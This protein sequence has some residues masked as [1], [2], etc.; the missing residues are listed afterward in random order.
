MK[1]GD[2][3]LL[4]ALVPALLGLPGTGCAAPAAAPRWGVALDGY[5]IT[6]AR[7]DEVARETTLR[8]RLVAFFQQWP[9]DPAGRNF[10]AESLAAIAAAGAEPVITWE[11]MYY[12]RADG[13]EVMI[14]AEQITAGV[15]DGYLEDYARQ[16]AAW[17]RPV[18]LRFAHEMNL[19]RYHW[20]SDEAGYGPSSPDRYVRM[21]RHV[22]AVFRR[23]GAANVRWA[24]CPNAESVPG[25]GN[26]P[27]AGWNVARAYY[28]GDAWVDL[29]GMDGYNWG[30]TQVPER[31]G[32]RSHW[33]SAAET[34]GAI[35]RELTALAPGKPLLIMETACAPTGGSKAAW[36]AEL[37]A[38]A[39]DW[40]LDGVIW[41]QANKEVDWRLHPGLSA[42]ELAA[43]RA[44]FERTR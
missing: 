35:R 25:P 34:F 43:F 12:R 3:A 19:R 18:I 40:K 24:F 32:W 2:L 10:P 31:H 42:A 27:D 28:P 6:A 8:P 14:S 26:A 30:D 9:E 21:W 29:L 15:Y 7:L 13:R 38:V 20:G 44:A 11:P 1:R 4:A 41:F 5:P 36:L 39:R 22:V 37:A 33:R 23:A 17:G 16:A